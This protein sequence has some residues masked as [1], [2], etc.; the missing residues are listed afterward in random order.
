M[1][2]SKRGSVIW[3]GERWYQSSPEGKLVRITT[4]KAT[5]LLAAEIL[6]TQPGLRRVAN[7]IRGGE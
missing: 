3:Q 1:N 5:L 2:N 6:S 7:R 4:S